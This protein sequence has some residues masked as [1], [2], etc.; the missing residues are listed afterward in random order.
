MFAALRGW[1]RIGTACLGG[2]ALIY[3]WNWLP[4]WA[5][6]FIIIAI[7]ILLFDGVRRLREL[8]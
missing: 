5:R 6:F 1:D 7:P 8:R 2:G 4:T 3:S